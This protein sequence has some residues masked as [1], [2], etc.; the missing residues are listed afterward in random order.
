VNTTNMLMSPQIVGAGRSA[1][2]AQLLTRG[3]KVTREAYD[4]GK[5]L[6]DYGYEVMDRIVVG[7]PLTLAHALLRQEDTDSVDNEYAAA[8]IESVVEAQERHPGHP[9]RGNWPRWVGDKEITDLNSAPFILRWLIPLLYSHGHQLPGDLLARCCESLRLALDELVRMDVSVTY[10]NIHLKTLFA[11]IIGGEWLGDAGFQ[12]I[13]KQRWSHWVRYTTESGA[14]REYN[15]ATYMGMNLT[16]L[17]KLQA[18]TE[19]PVI[20]LQ[21]RLLYERFWLHAALHIHRPTRQLAGP[22]ARCYWTPMLMGRE[23]LMEI[24]WRETGW[25][26]LLQPGPYPGPYDGHG[27]SCL[28]NNLELA[29]TEH[30]LPTF[31]SSWL[32]NQELALPCE[33]R[34]TASVTD[35]YDLTTYLTP[36]Y[37]LGTA[38]RTYS[39]GTG[40]LA[41]EQMANHLMLHYARPGQPG[42]WGMMYS[43]Y[44]VND[45]HWGT[46][47]SFAFRP[48]TNFFDQGHF[49]GVQLRNKTIAL[50]ALMPLYNTY[51]TSL[52]TVVVFQ[53]GDALERVCVNDRQVAWDHMS[54]TLQI[55]D[56]VIVEDGA[57]YIGIRP[58]QPTCLSRDTPIV[59]ERGPLGELFLSIYNYRGAEKRFWDYASLGGAYWRGNLRA[60]FVVEVAERTEYASA[61]GF[62][63]YLQSTTVEDTVDD[64]FIRTVVYRSGHDE[65]ALR[66]DLWNTEPVERRING[67]VYEPPH[68]ES[69]LGVQGSGGHLSVGTATLLTNPQ[70]VWLIA[71]ELDPTQR[72]WIAVNPEDCSTPLRLETPCGVITAEEWSM[73]RLEWQAPVGGEQILIVDSL[74]EPVGLKVPKDV[75][76][77]YMAGA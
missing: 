28:P 48:E 51:V 63:S 44:V 61:E 74:T 9:H 19:D 62:L 35:G 12:E 45:Q 60:G 67:N 27:A 66:Y 75:K 13:G 15:S 49:A 64:E 57:V 26:W 6:E 17:A 25:S 40:I 70:Q 54:D 42:G 46:L 38:S 34:E 73:G 18:M 23:R 7:T 36:T 41:I 39:T 72:A 31:V 21:A 22:H 5:Y 29:M 68:L 55:G 16:V 30:W 8:I 32:G 47:S 76:I 2:I 56:W 11:L 59:F 33:V 4:A 50:Y 3:I 52:K 1:R 65:M 43:R 77:H 14:P 20:R 10:T 24:L 71:Q 58:L 69:P 37:A 53:S